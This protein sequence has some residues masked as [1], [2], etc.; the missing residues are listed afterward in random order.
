MSD[1]I[2]VAPPNSL[3]GI[4]DVKKGEVPDFDVESGISATDS[5]I[6]VGCWPEIDGETEIILGLA[7]EVDPGDPAAF[8]GQLETPS[9]RVQ[10]VTI[11]WKTLL[12]AT[13][14]IAN[15]RVRIWPNRPRFPDRI[16]I[17]LD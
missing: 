6:L 8:D 1:S 12:E 14:S 5:C 7:S 9:G 4:S 16:I 17:G 11:E 13:G 10:V 3:I 2:K 15:T